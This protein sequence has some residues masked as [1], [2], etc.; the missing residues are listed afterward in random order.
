MLASG[1]F[2]GVAKDGVSRR[3]LIAAGVVACAAP[4][5]GVA[6]AR[7]DDLSVQSLTG[8]WAGQE[9]SVFGAMTLTVLFFP[10]GTYQ[11]THRAGGLFTYDNGNYE[12][13]QNWIHFHLQDFGPT[14]FMGKPMNW[15]SSDT[16]EVTAFDGQ[17]LVATIGGA[18]V[19][20][21]KG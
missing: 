6:P 15:P 2:D 5:I 13:V 21:M 12:I 17:S 19:R 16:W 11:R 1:P 3:A 14:Q 7:A 9:I 4:L 10:N 20:V 18:E 8:S